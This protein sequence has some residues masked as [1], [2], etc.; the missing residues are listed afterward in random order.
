MCNPVF[1]VVATVAAGAMQAYGQYQQGQAAQKAAQYNA[2]VSEQN[3]KIAEQYARA[4]EDRGAEE[5]RRKRIDTDRIISRQQAVLAAKGIDISS[6]TPLDIIGDTALYG[7]LD[8]QTIEYNAAL[9]AY[10]QRSQASNLRQQATLQRFEGDNAAQAGKI[11]AVGTLIGTAAKAGTTYAQFSS[12]VPQYNTQ[13]GSAG[14][15][16][17][18]SSNGTVIYWR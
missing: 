8:A 9:E 18:R 5:A 11:G 16:A 4:A 17:T 6:G 13:I 15:A 10:Q 12:N 3:A 2:A 1:S 14:A 7:E